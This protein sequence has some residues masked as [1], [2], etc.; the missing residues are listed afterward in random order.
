MTSA[1]W[2][3]DAVTIKHVSS[4]GQIAQW[5]EHLHSKREVVGCGTNPTRTNFL[6]TI[7]KTLAQNE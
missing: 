7:A 6:N 4:Y 2:S 1:S 3:L 5:L